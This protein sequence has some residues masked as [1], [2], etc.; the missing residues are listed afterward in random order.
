[1]SGRSGNARNFHKPARFYTNEELSY[2][3]EHFWPEEL[4][5][6]DF[7]KALELPRSTAGDLHS[8]QVPFDDTFISQMRQY[9][10]TA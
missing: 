1:M 10:A 2:M 5:V 4:S 7:A 8:G 6:D 9:L 3:P